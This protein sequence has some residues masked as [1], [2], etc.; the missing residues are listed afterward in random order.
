MLDDQ[1]SQS[2]HIARLQFCCDE[3]ERRTADDR[4]D[5]WYWNIK[6]KIAWFLKRQ[7]ERFQRA[8][9]S[10]L[11]AKQQVE[12]LANDP[13]LQSRD[14][15]QSESTMTASDYAQEFRA[16]AKR[17]LDSMYGNRENS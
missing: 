13:L 12:L 4:S 7:S 6:R 3:L 11:S 1:E 10:A 14:F 17:Y 5:A 16:K 9:P 15:R 2:F 8:T